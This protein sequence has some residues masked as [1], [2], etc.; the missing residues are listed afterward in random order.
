ME[1]IKNI[2]AGLSLFVIAG[3]I[4]WLMPIS[5]AVIGLYALSLIGAGVIL[6]IIGGMVRGVL[7]E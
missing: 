1:V 5:L 7:N 6:Y 3:V 2:L 4:T